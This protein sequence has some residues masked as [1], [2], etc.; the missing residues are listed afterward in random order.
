VIFLDCGGFVH[1]EFVPSRRTVNQ[2]YY[3]GFCDVWGSMPAENIWNDGR[4]RKGSFTMKMRRHTPL[5]LCSNFLPLKR[6]W[7]STLLTCLTWPPYDFL[8][9]GMKLQLKRCSFPGRL[10]NSGT[11]TDHPT[12]NSKTSVSAVHPAV[13]EKL[14]PL[15][16][17]RRG[18]LWRWQQQPITKERIYFVTDS[19]QE[20]FFIHPRNATDKVPKVTDRLKNLK[21]NSLQ[22]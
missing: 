11:I 17:L 13:T 10:W 12:R 8:H 1:Q 18:L 21:L 22:L 9:L 19:V 5:C 7:S 4:T 3:Q 20:F 6:L 15:H 16:K 2:R 14:D